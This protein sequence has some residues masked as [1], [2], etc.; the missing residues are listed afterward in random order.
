MEKHRRYKFKNKD[1]EIHMKKNIAILLSCI[2]ICLCGCSNSSSFGDIE[3]TNRELDMD[4]TGLWQHIEYP[5]SYSAII[6]GQSGNTVNLVV[7]ATQGGGYGRK[8]SIRKENITI[9]S[10]NES[11][12]DYQDTNGN[13]GTCHLLLKE[14]TIFLGFS[15]NEPYQGA[16]CIDAANG[17]FLKA[18][19]LSEMDY[20]DPQEY[21]LDDNMTDIKPEQNNISHGNPTDPFNIIDYTVY[22]QMVGDDTYNEDF[23]LHFWTEGT[24]EKENTGNIV[25]RG[26]YTFYNSDNSEYDFMISMESDQGKYIMFYGNIIKEKNIIELYEY[27]PDNEY[28]I[29]WYGKYISQAYAH[30]FGSMTR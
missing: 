23:A 1:G 4:Y 5:D 20:F 21:G 26:I 11:V 8:V 6:Y 25:E 15:V 10:A 27:N 2:L 9:N 12:F 29:S 7:S 19:E 24:Y 30:S 3:S 16:F 17:D 14:Q 13:T 22:Y 18:K 28:P